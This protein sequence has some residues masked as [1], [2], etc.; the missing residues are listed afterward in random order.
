MYSDTS[1]QLINTANQ[2]SNMPQTAVLVYEYKREPASKNG[3]NIYG[4]N[5]SSERSK[6]GE[7]H[8]YR[9]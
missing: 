3:F 5:A 1:H 8:T 2:L 9:L 7:G 6:V 4:F